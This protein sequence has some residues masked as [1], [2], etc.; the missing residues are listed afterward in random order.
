MWPGSGRMSAGKRYGEHRIVNVPAR[1]A[2]FTLAV[3][4]A[5]IDDVVKLVIEQVFTASEEYEGSNGATTLALL[6]P[7]PR[8]SGR[9]LK[10]RTANVRGVCWEQGTWAE[11]SMQGQRG[12][13]RTVLS[14]DSMLRLIQLRWLTVVERRQHVLRGTHYDVVATRK[15]RIGGSGIV[16]TPKHQKKSVGG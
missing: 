14:S 12:W 8:V 9:F 2:V 15:D 3:Y 4:L 11:T 1:K 6:T 13:R 10:S 5:S 7:W 16:R